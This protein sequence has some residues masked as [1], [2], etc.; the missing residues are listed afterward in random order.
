MTRGLNAVPRP[1]NPDFVE[2]IQRG[3][4]VIRAFRVDR[5]ALS[6]SEVAAATGLARPT[7]RRVLVTLQT[8]GYV[9]S[10]D[11][12]FR[13]TPRVLDLG[14]AYVASMGLWDLV[15]PHLQD[16]VARTRESSS[17]SQLDGSEIVYVGRVAVPKIV[18]IAVRLGTRFP[19]VATSMGRVL[20]AD[21]SAEQLQAA[22]AAPLRGGVTPMV[23]PDP[24]YL[25]EVLEETRARGWALIDQELAVGVRSVAAPV[26]NSRGRTVAA[27]NICVQAAEYGT[28]QL[29]GR[30]LPLLLDTASAISADVA[31]SERVAE[32]AVPS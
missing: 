18:T 24:R 26:R 25:A 4:D 2:A 11:R 21:L 30:F 32:V 22:L 6:L 19:A 14:Y 3:L 27:I 5:P 31:R 17:M 15:H 29:T 7:A 1:Q 9:R 16:L 10:E 12:L 13:L 23:T 20:L 8:L 28:D